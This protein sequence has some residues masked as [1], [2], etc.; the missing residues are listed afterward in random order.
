MSLQG[1]VALVTGGGRGIGADTTTLL[2]ARGA[3]VAVNYLSNAQAAEGV[4][5]AIRAASGE[6]FAV[7]ADVRDAHQV[8]RL[9][10]S[11][12]D[13]YGRLNILA[14]ELWPRG[15]TAN[16]VSPGGVETE[17]SSTFLAA[18][19]KQR[20]A[21]AIPPGLRV[22][23]EDIARVI[24]FFAD[25]DSGFKTGTCVPVTGGMELARAGAVS[26]VPGRPAVQRGE[27]ERHP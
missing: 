17:G 8:A 1:K 18:Q 20:T 16:V 3:R 5:T 19:F 27:D 7:Q 2:A 13:S 4:V 23:P 21:S 6:A 10:A 12:I 15:I 9:V 14:Y 26:T 24:A 22:Q 25:D 11:V